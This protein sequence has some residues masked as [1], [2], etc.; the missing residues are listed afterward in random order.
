MNTNGSGAAPLV[1]DAIDER[2]PDWGVSYAPPQAT[3][4]SPQ[5]FQDVDQ[6]AALDA[7]Y[8]CASGSRALVS[9]Q[10][11]ADSAPVADGGALPTRSLGWH[12]LRVQAAD[13][14][15]EHHG[16]RPQLPGAR[17]HPARDQHLVAGRGRRVR[18]RPDAASVVLLLRS[19]AGVR[20]ARCD[21]TDASAGVSAVPGIGDHEFT[22]RATDNE[23]NTATRVV[24]YRVVYPWLGFL[25]ATGGWRSAVAGQKIQLSFSL[26]GY[27]G[28]PA[29]RAARRRTLP[30]LRRRGAVRC[31]ATTMPPAGTQRRR[32]VAYSYDAAS[33]QYTYLWMTEPSWAGTCR[34]FVIRLNDGTKRTTGIQFT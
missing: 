11:F 31:T 13:G 6:F 12:T 34:L 32:R 29:A 1:Q 23:G 5:S 3:I 30:R 21:A 28:P 9:C 19:A 24:H 7:S 33:D 25:P 27:A 26:G 16:R 4:S 2:S 14:A 18:Q 22:V 17:P 15:G 8:S 10:G 20:L